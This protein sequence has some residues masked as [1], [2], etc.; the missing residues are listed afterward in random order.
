M[1]SDP[2]KSLGMAS[3]A[4]ARTSL[5]HVFVRDFVLP[6]SIGWH[7]HEKEAEQRV[8]FNLDLAVREGQGPLD[9]HLSNVVDYEGICDGVR[10]LVTRGHVNLVETL[11]EDVAEMCLV[12]PRVR[13]VR[14]KVEKLDIMPDA[15]SVGVEIE[16]FS[17]HL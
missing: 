10:A 8:R 5:R 14:V 1:N 7:A 2:Y 9:D 15:V 17:M 16:R 12:D 13:S 4:D 3:L 6:V 11:A